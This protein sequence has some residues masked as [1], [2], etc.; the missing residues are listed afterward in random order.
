[1]KK[2]FFGILIFLLASTSGFSQ[3][4]GWAIGLK[5]G[6]PLGLNIRKYISDGDK[7]IDVNFGTFGFLYGRERSY[8]KE[9]R[10]NDAGVMFQALLHYRRT[11]GA[12]DRVSVYYGYGAQINSRNRIPSIG[13]NDKFKI[14]SLGP[15]VNTG[16]EVLLPDNDLSLF[17]DAGGYAEIVPKFLFVAPNVNIGLRLNLSNR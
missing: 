3:D 7:A 17:L 11:L 10:Y 12:A 2:C 14:I 6:E 4:N 9:E 16:I 1:M 5:V 13:N 8:R 15:A